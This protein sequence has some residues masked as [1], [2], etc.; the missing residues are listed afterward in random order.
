[1]ITLKRPFLYFLLHWSLCYRYLELLKIHSLQ[2]WEHFIS[3][4]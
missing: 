1:M 3:D 2:Q 4:F